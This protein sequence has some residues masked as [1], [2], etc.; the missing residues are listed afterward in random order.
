LEKPKNEIGLRFLEGWST[1]LM[2]SKCVVLYF[3]YLMLLEKPIDRYCSCSEAEPR[4][5][6]PSINEIRSRCM[7]YLDRMRPDH[8]RRL[9]PTP[10]KVLLLL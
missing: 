10:Y 3:S 8:M 4:E 5:E 2:S 9:N 7:G 1:K 6:L